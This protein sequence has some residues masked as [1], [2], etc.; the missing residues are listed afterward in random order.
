MLEM[1]CPVLIHLYSLL[2]GL[3]RG[4]SSK[5]PQTRTKAIIFGYVLKGLASLLYSANLSVGIISEYPIGTC[6]RRILSTRNKKKVPLNIPPL[7]VRDL[8]KVMQNSTARC[9]CT[10][11]IFCLTRSQWQH[12]RTRSSGPAVDQSHKIAV[13]HNYYNV[14]TQ[15]KENHY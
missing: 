11:R 1:T 14:R 5:P 2:H 10:N 3:V 12:A 13:T 15:F 8:K 9:E 6:T 7:A 4:N